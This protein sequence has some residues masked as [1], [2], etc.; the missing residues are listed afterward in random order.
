MKY[1]G[2]PFAVSGNR[3]AVPVVTQ[4][5]G[6]VNF[7]DGYGVDY[8]LDPTVDPNAILIERTKFNQLMYDITSGI[9]ALQIDFPAFVAAADNA[10]VAVN[11]RAG[12]VVRMPN[13][14]LYQATAATN[15]IPPA[16]PWIVF[17]SN[18]AL[19]SALV[20]EVNR[21]TA[22]EALLAP[23]DAPTF[24]GVPRAPTAIF[25][26]TGNQLATLSFVASAV[27]AEVARAT[28]AEA[29]LAPLDSPFLFGVP[30]TVDPPPSGDL[31]YVIVNFNNLDLAVGNERN[32][33]IG[34]ENT[35]APLNSPGFTGTP[36]TGTP[37]PD[38]ND[39]TIPNTAWVRS[40]LPSAAG[41]PSPGGGT[42]WLVRYARVGVPIGGS[43][44]IGGF[45]WDSPF[46]TACLAAIAGAEIN[47]VFNNP[48]PGN[49]FSANAYNFNAT[50]GLI[51]VDTEQGGHA[52]G[53]VPVDV[54]GIGY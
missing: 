17:L 29:L 36:T 49:N 18:Y 50:G 47:D 14:I 38:S 13:T 27:A 43:F 46:P 20:A 33:A 6:T 11:Y 45:T 48:S 2:V 51:R 10:G 7:T 15:A 31:H 26:A 19:T 42:G 1:Y 21:A 44:A 23:I 22:A 30:Q 54:I 28:A 52:T 34:V 12:A 41:P 3:A 53:S 5:D 35:K 24:T 8:A 39:A 32:R 40:L 37:P 25:G 16:A 9:G 4:P